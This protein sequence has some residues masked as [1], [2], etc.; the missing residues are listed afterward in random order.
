MEF[1]MNGNDKDSSYRYTVPEFKVNIAGRGNGIYTIFYNVD[2]ISKKINH[3]SDII[4]K[5]IASITGSNYI[6][7]RNTITGTHK[8][9]ELKEQLLT[10]I[11]YLVMC[12]KCNIP[13]TIP[14]LTST[15]KKSSIELFCS[16]CKNV[17][18]INI[19]NKN[20]DKGIDIIIK[21]LKSGKEWKTTKGN[22]VSI[23]SKSNEDS[24]DID[25]FDI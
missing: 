22:M 15:K 3:P 17:S 14:Q 16:A 5:Y 20:I 24:S 23:D 6:P 1:N 21:Y 13:E 12:P 19:P 4:F 18:P 2:D 7:E 8:P 9:D 10:Y 11:K 25:P